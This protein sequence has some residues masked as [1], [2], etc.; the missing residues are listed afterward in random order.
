MPVR[1]SRAQQEFARR[2]VGKTLRS[3]DIHAAEY[4]RQWGRKVRRPRLLQACVNL[5]PKGGLVLDLGCGAGQDVRGLRRRHYRAFGL[6]LSKILL[7][8]ARRGS[9][10]M[11]L[12]RADMR[13]LPLRRRV[14]DG[15]WAAAS[16]IHLPKP[17]AK[18][19]LRELHDLVRPGGMLAA[20][21]VYG[22]SSGFL[23]TGWIAGRYMVRWRKHE[24]IAAVRRAG[25]TVVS[26]ET[27]A[28]RER[29]G[30][31]LNLLARRPIDTRARPQKPKSF[32]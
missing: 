6:D 1:P 22:R 10:R 20:T 27:V 9:R 31:W 23:K 19:L 32:Q 12:V 11:P 15:V 24:L 8:H 17:T 16:L 7:R 2:V 28:N 29:K 13:D 25:W 5:L 26:L 21:F 30:R 3:Y 4:L 18:N 14:L